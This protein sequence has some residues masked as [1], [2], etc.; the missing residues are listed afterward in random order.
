M[1]SSLSVSAA[2]PEPAP[3]DAAPVAPTVSAQPVTPP[4]AAPGAPVLDRVLPCGLRVLVAQDD[5]LPV[6]AVVLAVERGS[7]DDPS[8]LP[9][10]HHALAYQLLQGN[11]TMPPGGIQS[12]VQDGGGIAY[13]ATGPAQIRF[14]SLVPVSLLA[15]VIEAEAERFIAPTVTE[16]LWK[17]SLSAARRDIPRKRLAPRVALAAAHGVRGLDHDGRAVPPALGELEVRAVQTRLDALT[18]YEQATLV[19][20][21]PTERET[22]MATIEAAFA[23]HPARPRSV[24]KR[25]VAPTA[26]VVKSK[27]A[28]GNTFVWALPG[29]PAARLW[30]EAWCEALSRQRRAK[31]EPKTSQVRCAF[32]DDP[33]RPAVTVRVRAPEDPAGLLAA[34]FERLADG[35]RLL[36]AQRRR[37]ERRNDTELAR[38]LSLARRLSAADPHAAP[39]VPATRTLSGAVAL[40]ASPPA[41]ADLLPLEAAV[42]VVADGPGPRS[43]TAPQAP[44][45]T[46][47]D[48]R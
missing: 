37:M 46:A 9:G 38:P 41:L 26:T 39:E 19:V 4:P 35:G 7:E 47:E 34:R 32:E 8:E 36:Q 28:K 14:E 29:T 1:S 6:A 25:V 22:T 44:A 11:R 43:R 23:D 3:E 33:R 45:K 18:R 2:P 21:A 30:G 13:L 20:V 5:S 17:E 15:D 16:A 12:M 10:L 24:A 42:R 31:S 27:G 40:D 48:E